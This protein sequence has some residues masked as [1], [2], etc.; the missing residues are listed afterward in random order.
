MQPQFFDATADK[1]HRIAVLS[2]SSF[3]HGNRETTPQVSEQANRWVGCP[4]GIFSIPLAL[5]VL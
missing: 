1:R 2:T 4:A 5:L 3:R